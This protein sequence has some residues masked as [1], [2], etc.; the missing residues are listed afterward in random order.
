MKLPVIHVPVSRKA[1]AALVVAG[2]GALL[3]LLGIYHVS[4]E[5]QS[6]IS[7]GEAG[8]AAFAVGDGIKYAN[9]LAKKLGLPVEVDPKA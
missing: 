2:V 9:Y 6:L 4:A 7:A 5:A 8:V 3:P 1:V